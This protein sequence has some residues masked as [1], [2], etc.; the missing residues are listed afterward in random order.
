M[1]GIIYH[2]L[3]ALLIEEGKFDKALQ[4]S[5]KSYT[6]RIEEG[7]LA[8][9]IK[10]LINLGSIYHETGKDFESDTSYKKALLLAEKYAFTEDEA[11]IL[12]HLGY[13]NLENNELQNA[14]KYFSKSMILA[15]DLSDKE[16]QVQ[17]HNYLFHVDSIQGNFESA[18][19]HIQQY[20]K[21]TSE[22]DISESEKK[23]D[24]LENLILLAREENSLN[25]NIIHRNKTLINGLIVGIIV[26]VLITILIV[27][28]I[29]LRSQRK[30]AELTQENLRTQMNPHFIF[31]ILNSIHSFMLNK[32]TKSSSRYLLKFSQL[33][34]LT[35]DNSRCKLAT[36]NDEVNA[37]KIYLELESMRFD[38]QLE[39][40]IIIDEEID[41][42]MFKIPT[43]LLQPY[44]ENSILHG[45]QGMKE[46]GKIEVRMDYKN[47][48]I[49]CSIM[50]N[51]IG[52]KRAETLKREKGIKYK[53]HGS[54]ITETRIKLL[55]KLYGRK[56]G[57]I[58]TEILDKDENCN[59]TKVEF[60]LPILN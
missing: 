12:M 9:Q 35:L 36:I 34:R 58:Y 4:A 6:I 40:E 53:S 19:S 31:N 26:L 22:F 50:D 11:Y 37:L 32:D 44:V 27:Q 42:L 57:V 46:K 39:Y 52:R 5:I 38:N 49:H 60:D 25:E 21:L 33:L 45:I 13:L 29:L 16:L 2:N 3:G 20:N 48:G 59:G 15:E 41:P 43:L 56:F 51:G 55:N 23:L 24:E 7:Y 1:L 30:T 8:G 47:N 28:Q 17:L 18:L 14:S 54:D 10:C